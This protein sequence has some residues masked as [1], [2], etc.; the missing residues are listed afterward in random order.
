MN[1]WTAPVTRAVL[2]EL[3]RLRLADLR[4]PGAVEWRAAERDLLDPWGR[5]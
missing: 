1:A 5:L 2:R 4:Q 3:H